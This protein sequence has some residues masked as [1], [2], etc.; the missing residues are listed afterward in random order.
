M[1]KESLRK[2]VELAGGQAHLARGIRARI[3]GS[4]IGQGHVS[5]WL[6]Q[7]RIEVPPAEVVIPIAQFLDYRMTPHELR[8]DLYPNPND[9]LPANFRQVGQPLAND[10]IIATAPQGNTGVKSV[11]NAGGIA[12]VERRQGERREGV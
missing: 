9:A 5:G 7:V 2:S 12:P 10:Q 1:S 4:K 11:T 6:N 8:P 3:P